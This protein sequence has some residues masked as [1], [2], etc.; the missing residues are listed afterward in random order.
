MGR[1]G[2]RRW[3]GGVNVHE[4]CLI[5]TLILTRVVG[6]GGLEG[7]LIG[8]GPCNNTAFITPTHLNSIFYMFYLIMSSALNVN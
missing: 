3:G 5:P 6:D 4:A 8:Y 2:V 1:T 7:D